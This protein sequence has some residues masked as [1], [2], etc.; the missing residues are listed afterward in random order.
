MKSSGRALLLAAAF[1]VLWAAPARADFLI[2]P[3][4]GIAAGGIVRDGA[5]PTYTAQIGLFGTGA[6]VGF[7][8]DYGYTMKARGGH[9]TDNFRTLGAAV[10]IAVPRI[11][12]DRWR[13]YVAVGGGVIGAVS[14]VRHL[15]AFGSD[16][17]EASGVAGI[18]GG[19]F[20]FLSSHVGIRVDARY[21]R[22]L[23]D[24]EGDHGGGETVSPHFIRASA[25]LVI[26]F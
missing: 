4:I 10:L 12:S 18:G 19:L 1:S 16:E 26:R 9:H 8:L 6:P 21:F 20:G 5:K 25:G 17:V 14:R 15:Y 2:C 11:G 22:A 24:D 13:P 23:I 3:G 7:E